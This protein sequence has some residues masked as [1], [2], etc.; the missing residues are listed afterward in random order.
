[1]DLREIELEKPGEPPFEP[2]RRYPWLWVGVGII[3]VLVVIG[4]VV[5]SRRGA[6]DRVDVSEVRPTGGE[7]SP[8][9][10]LGGDAA[11]VELPPLDESDTVVRELVRRLSTHPTVLAWLAGDNLA[12]GFVAATQNI[13]GGVNP[14]AHVRRLAP[15]GEFAVIERGGATH[16]DPRSYAR[17]D[18]IADA[19][20]SVDPRGAA[21]LYA[22]LKPRLTEA[23]DELGTGRS[24]DQA[25]EEALVRLLQT[26]VLNDPVRVVPKGAGYAY[27]DPALENLTPP[28]KQLM[29]MGPRN[30]QI[31]QNKLREI[32]TALGIDANR[33]PPPAET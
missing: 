32:A 4:Y 33:L 15:T 14:T 2:P 9:Q 20:A 5:T 29:R 8:S 7:S 19:V 25:L 13:A 27:A 21:D 10:P 11:A 1:M 26:P 30:T 17:Y 12:R 16:I 22:T 24:L 31:I 3:V 28:Q 23:H 6:T 18:R